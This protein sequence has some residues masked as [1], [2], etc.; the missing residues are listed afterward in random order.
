MISING[1][2]KF[3]DFFEKHTDKYVLIGGSACSI[4]FDEVG[5]DFRATKDLDVVLIVEN[6]GEDFGKAFWEFVKEANYNNIETGEVQNQFYRFKN[7]KNND[8]PKMI[9]LFSRKPQFDLL[10][11]SHLTPI[12]I[13]DDV[14]SLSAILLD[15]DYYAFLLEGRRIIDGFSVLDEKY[16]IPFKAK[17]WCELMERRRNGEEG[18]SKHIKKHY[19]DVFRLLMLLPEQEKIT[20]TNQVRVDMETFINGI[21]QGLFVSEDIDNSFLCQKLREIYLAN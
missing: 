2:F 15:D 16:L 9:E 19:R 14:S 4:V 12:H 6:I 17:A 7:P 8:F 20:L 21:E 11:N 18:N 10:P 5:E 3:R 1:L 13:A